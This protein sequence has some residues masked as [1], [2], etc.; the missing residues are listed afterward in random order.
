[1]TYILTPNVPELVP[2]LAFVLFKIPLPLTIIQIL[3]VDLGTDILPALALGAEAP[4]KD[5]MK[6]PPRARNERLLHWPL[7][8]RAHLLLGVT[9]AIAAMAV[10]FLCSACRRLDLWTDAAD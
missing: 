10:F 5:V 2:Y 7:L 4:H 3:A 9:G 1:M 8:G 6:N